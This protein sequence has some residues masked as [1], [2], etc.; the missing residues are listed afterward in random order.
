MHHLDVAGVRAQVL[1]MRRKA[2]SVALC[3]RERVR[4]ERRERRERG[5]GERGERERN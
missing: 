5:G 2:R 1:R 4:R 3:V